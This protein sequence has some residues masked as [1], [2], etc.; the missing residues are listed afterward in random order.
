M[1]SGRAIRTILVLA[2]LA[3][4]PGCASGDPSSE[5][6]DVPAARR[7]QVDQLLAS[8]DVPGPQR[9]ALEDYVVTDREFQQA[10]DALRQCLEPYEFNVTL[11]D[12]GGMDV[13]YPPEY[14]AKFD[15]D[16]EAADAGEVLIHE[17][18]VAHSAFVEM[19]YNG[20][21]DNPDGLTF[22]EAVRAC[23]DRL[24]LEEGRDLT[25]DELQD[26]LQADESFLPE[27]RLDPWSV[28]GD[29]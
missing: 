14:L 3:A 8:D 10:R 22:V 23:I 24:G 9:E 29:D 25:D 16:L 21:R 26:R 19:V 11:R 20:Q 7:A 17:C 13:E 5:R 1:K 27:C 6:A 4:L 2:L 15:S 18:E 12:D 28:A